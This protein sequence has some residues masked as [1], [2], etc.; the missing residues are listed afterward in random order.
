MASS[1]E[2]CHQSLPTRPNTHVPIA[3]AYE[4]PPNRPSSRDDFEIAIICALTVETDAALALFDWDWDKAGLGFGKLQGDRNEYNTGVIGSHN[5]VLAHMPEPGN[6]NA[7]RV[8]ANCQFSFPQRK[9]ALIVGVCGAV[10]FWPTSLNTRPLGSKPGSS[11]S[12]SGRDEIVLGDVIISDGIM[13]YDF[14][15]LKPGGQYERKNL[16]GRP[17]IEMRALLKKAKAQEN[18]QQLR[19]QMIHALGLLQSVDH[20]TATYPTSISDWLFKA[21][22]RHVKDGESCDR[23]CSKDELLLR[24]RVNAA[25]GNPNPQ[26][27]VGLIA[28]GDSVV[29]SGEERDALSASDGI[30]AF[31]MEAAGVWESIP[32][33]VIKGACDYA[34]SHKNKDWQSYAAATAASCMK[35]FLTSC[36]SSVPS[37][38][39]ILL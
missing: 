4:P 38:T 23:F 14:G 31:E 3:E 9:L 2:N 17:S 24:D 37:G 36:V 26:I 27:H 32:C 16:L 5:V 29:M 1:V 10:P 30:I 39:R 35:A 34:D 20:L 19:E 28:S 7:A 18:R 22:Y 13:H 6:A 11:K 8:A 21:A 25:K 12:P 15:R 33:V